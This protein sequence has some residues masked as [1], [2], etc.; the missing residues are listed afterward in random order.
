[1]DASIVVMTHNRETVLEKTV[2]AMLAQEFNGQF[3]VIVVNDGSTDGTKQML[4][5][6]EKNSKL[7]V[8]NQERSLPCRA[9]N[10][11]IKKTAYEITVIMDDDCIPRSDWL[12]RIV[13][14]F[15][16]ETIGMVSSYSVHGGTST[17]F[18]TEV[19]KKIGGFDEE[20]GYY[21]EDTDLVF[22]IQKQGFK[23]RLVKAPFRHEHKME[24]PKGL[25][26]LA[27]YG[28]ERAVYHVNDVLLFKKHPL[29]AKEFL[30]VKLGFFVNPKKD[31]AAATNKWW[32]GGKMKLAS[33][34]GIVFLE[35]KSP[36]HLAVIFAGAVSWVFLVK[37]FRLFGSVKFRKLLI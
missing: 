10:N 36:L 11:G 34:R 37:F 21:R 33:P 17:A 25:Y 22:R 14:G 3:E 12:Q 27:Q 24:K 29:L 35:N 23:T 28:L 6:F 32:S 20:Y 26:G 8:I 15:S 16:D 18:R 4:E 30:D 31:F 1:M 9:R 13:N 5:K 2:N 19:L 7:K